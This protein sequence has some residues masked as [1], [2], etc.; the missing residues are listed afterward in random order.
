MSLPTFSR[1]AELV[2]AR[3]AA[4]HAAAIPAEFGTT[5][6]EHDG[7]FVFSSLL[8]DDA[9]GALVGQDVQGMRAGLRLH[10]LRWFLWRG[11]EVL[12]QRAVAG[13]TLAEAR[14]WLR[15]AAVAAGL[16]D[17]D[18]E[19]ATWE[20]PA[21]PVLD[22]APFTQSSSADLEQLSR[23]FRFAASAIEAVAAA[24]S[25]ASTTR[26]WPHHFDIATLITLDPDKDAEEARSVGV[27][28]SPGDGGIAEPYVYVTPWPAPS[29]WVGPELPAGGI[30]HTEGWF[31][32][33]LRGGLLVDSSDARAALGAFLD[34]AIDTSLT[35]V[36]A[37]AS[38]D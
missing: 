23:W 3:V 2:A 24:Q 25:G 13:S 27:G 34:Q 29:D 22:G 15:S 35:L 33:V 17:K 1:S 14:A 19:S 28:L 12:A 9:R 26:V 4:H 5:W 21:A 11:D 8:W 20:M 18:V 32:A 7:G 36:R 31:G 6:L 16:E 37:R 10:D 38:S 30:W